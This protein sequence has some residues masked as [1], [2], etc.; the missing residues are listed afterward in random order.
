MLRP[1]KS[2]ESLST[3]AINHPQRT[4]SDRV[5]CTTAKPGVAATLLASENKSDGIDPSSSNYNQPSV[6]N[7]INIKDDDAKRN[8]SYRNESIQGT[9]ST[10]MMHQSGSQQ[11]SSVELD[12]VGELEQVAQ[13]V[14]DLKRSIISNSRNSSPKCHSRS[15]SHDSY[16]ER[17]LASSVV[18]FKMEDDVDG[19]DISVESPGK[20]I[21]NYDNASLDLSEIQV[22][23]ELEDNEMKIFSE[24]EA[25]LSNSCGS[26]LSKSLAGNS[27]FDDDMH[28]TNAKC[29]K[30]TSKPANSE[31]S[32]EN[33]A[34]PKN[35]RMSFREKFRIFTSP[36][37]GRKTEGNECN[38]S[39]QNNT[40][41]DENTKKT[42]IKDKVLGTLSP[43]SMR[44][45]NNILV[46]S[47]STDDGT[48]Q[49]SKTHT[50][51]S[52]MKKKSSSPTLGTS[53][54]N[55]SNLVKRSKIERDEND[56][57]TNHVTDKT[58]TCDDVFE[59]QKEVVPCG[60][61][62][63]PSI[64]FM[65]ESVESTSKFNPSS[66]K[67]YFNS[68]IIIFIT[69]LN[70]YCTM[71]HINDFSIPHHVS[72]EGDVIIVECQTA[73][74]ASSNSH[75]IASSQNPRFSTASTSSVASNEESN[76]TKN[77][78]NDKSQLVIAQVHHDPIIE[79][80][81]EEE[82]IKGK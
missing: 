16:F 73:V 30:N 71:L 81:E 55:T 33:S 27:I 37:S 50:Q 46:N 43:E 6:E 53:P 66:G 51:I 41:K 57:I 58:E 39:H 11:L 28:S 24:D 8:I 74:S 72:G 62:L 9:E 52:P 49:A 20:N 17:K 78:S 19:Q 4:Q 21:N 80:K 7:S 22:N 69:I 75:Y 64:Q 35:R 34:S 47:I 3:A 76:G 29:S 32:E 61:P 60:I 38:E 48:Q 25:M 15:S 10:S 65:D 2:A 63:S 54:N 40:G 23:F 77:D 5:A 44:K 67:N 42:S 70:Y 68:F 12:K 56:Y 14:T 45:R 79:K 26:D 18:Q 82:N 1:V 59:A 31:M 36:N 13:A